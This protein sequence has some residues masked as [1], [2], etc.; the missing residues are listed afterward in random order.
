MTTERNLWIA[1]AL[2]DVFCVV[3]AWRFGTI[4]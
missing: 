4:I 2:F 1:L 3:S